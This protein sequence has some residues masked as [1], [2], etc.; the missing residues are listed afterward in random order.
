M[1]IW[2]CA[3]ILGPLME[4]SLRQSLILSQGDFMIF[5]RSPISLTALLVAACLLLTTVLPF[6]K[7]RRPALG[8]EK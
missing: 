2:D 7:T 5:V 3:F 4:K 6:F 1:G 8:I